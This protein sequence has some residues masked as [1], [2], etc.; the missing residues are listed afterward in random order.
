MPK[1]NEF[2]DADSKLR[3]ALFE[4]HAIA[5]QMFRDNL[6]GYSIGTEAR[7][8]L[9]KRGIGAESIETFELGLLGAVWPGAGS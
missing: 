6:R 9:T 8:Y 7:N 3:A 4:I 1:R 2:A 5:A